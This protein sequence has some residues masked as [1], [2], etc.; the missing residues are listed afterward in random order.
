MLLHPPVVHFAIAIPVV[1]SIFGL[2]YLFKRSE[3]L[4]K[5]SA[6]LTVFAAIAVAAAWYTGSKAGPQIYDY[7]GAA[8]QHEL[9]EHKELGLYLAIAFGVIAL[10]QFAGCQLKK[11]PLQALA[12]VALLGATA[13]VFVQGKDG[14]EIVYKYG[15]PFKAPMILESIKEA[16][17][18]AD[19]EE[20]CDAQVELYSDAVDDALSV[21]EEVQA[22]YAEPDE[23]AEEDDE[24]EDE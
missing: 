9:L 20:E 17:A 15:Q 12:I 19:D 21:S 23:H 14:G 8:G 6:R 16:Q 10:I 18:S 5:I 3:G 22:I 1:A 13:T 2:L 11:F 24:D 7:L 4:S